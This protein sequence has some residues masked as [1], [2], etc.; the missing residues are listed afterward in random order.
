MGS[1]AR[2][3]HRQEHGALRA[4]HVE[5]GLAQS[6]PGQPLDVLFQVVR[7]HQGNGDLLREDR[8]D[9][10]SMHDAADPAREVVSP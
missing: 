1:L 7:D 10:G 2:H 9:I 4:G 3:V 8:V 6:F 5:A